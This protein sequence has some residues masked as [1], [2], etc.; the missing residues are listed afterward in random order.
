M[1]LQR[2]LFDERG[3][4]VKCPVTD[5]YYRPENATVDQIDGLTYI[6]SACP[7]CDARGQAASGARMP[8]I[9]LHAMGGRDG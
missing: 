4:L 7:H 9:H 8:Q 1:A 3:I 6:Q 2:I 5:R